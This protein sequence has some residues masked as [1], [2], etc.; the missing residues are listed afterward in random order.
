MKDLRHWVTDMNHEYPIYHLYA[1]AGSGK[2]AIAR[3]LA[4]TFSGFNHLFRKHL[5]ASFFFSRTAEGRNST[6]NFITTLAYQVAINLPLAQPFVRGAID[7][8]PSLPSRNLSTQ[9]RSLIFNPL[10][11]ACQQA[12]ALEQAS[13]PRLIV[14]DGI[15]ECFGED[16]QINI[17]DAVTEL[18]K[19]RSFPLAIFLSCRPELHIRSAFRMGPLNELSQQISLSNQYESEHDIR[20]FLVNKFKDIRKAHSRIQEIPQDWPDSETIEVLVKKSSGHFIYAS[21][22]I[23]YVKALDDNP[24][25]R[26][27]VVRGLAET[28]DDEKPFAQL[29]TLYLH[30]LDSVKPRHRPVVM[31]VLR[32]I[33][34]LECPVPACILPF[35]EA[36]LSYGV[37]GLN[38]ILIQFTMNNLTF[39]HAS[40]SDF[41]LQ[42][43]RAGEHYV[44]LG[45]ARVTIGILLF[46][47]FVNPRK[48]TCTFFWF[49]CV[50]ASFR[51][52]YWSQGHTEPHS[53]NSA[54]I[55]R[56]PRP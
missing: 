43:N 56:K 51:S 13:W 11:L 36:T 14:L 33:L 38:D 47:N 2:T 1:P 40:F 19:S 49:L 50:Q 20:L 55:G 16:A 52:R 24:I 39:L 34:A 8:D 41:L 10:R 25:D 17:L 22:V 53:D 9:L 46:N 7:R 35:D 29:D 28:R 32:F 21:V 42:R 15:D 37:A 48:S 44:D 3:T 31:D 54:W 4:D 5:L 12:S 23:K 30:I 18:A 6:A 45:Q 27:K 26:L